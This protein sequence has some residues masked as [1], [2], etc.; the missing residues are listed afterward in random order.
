MVTAG[1]DVVPLLLQRVLAFMYVCT[2]LD[3]EDLLGCG[4]GQSRGGNDGEGSELHVDI[5]GWNDCSVVCLSGR[6]NECTR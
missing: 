6:G 1:T 5:R 2:G 4:G 3:K